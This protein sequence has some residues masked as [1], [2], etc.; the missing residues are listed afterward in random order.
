MLGEPEPF[1]GKESIMESWRKV[2]REGFAPLLP[3]AGLES[4]KAAN[5]ALVTF[6]RTPRPNIHDI[7]SLAD[8][9][10]SFASTALR[11]SSA[12]PST[13]PARPE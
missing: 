9:M 5:T 6:A 13:Q 12:V 1:A 2:W 10:N 4:M 8:A 11:L 7:G 3:T